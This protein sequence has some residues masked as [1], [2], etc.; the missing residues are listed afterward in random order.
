[1][2]PTVR[3]ELQELE[4]LVEEGLGN[5]E[6]VDATALEEH[7]QQEVERIKQ[8]LVHEVFSFEDER[9]LQ[10]YIQ[11]H[12]QGI[13]SLLDATGFVVSRERVAKKLEHL[14]TFIERHFAK[15]FDQ[16]AKAPEGYVR[17]VRRAFRQYAKRLF[18]ELSDRQ[19]EPRL[20]ELLLHAMWKLTDRRASG[21]TYRKV[22]YAKE[23]HLELTRLLSR[24]RGDP[25]GDINEELR[26]LLYYLNYN[27]TRALTY[28][29]HYIGGV[30]RDAETQEDKIDRLSLLLKKINQVQVRPG[31][32]YHPRCQSLKSQVNNY[33]TEEI[34]YLERLHQLGGGSGELRV[35][36]YRSGF[37]VQ[38]G[39]SVSQLSYL[40][41]VL[42]GCSVIE[43][44]NVAELL[45]FIARS[46]VT[47]QSAEVSFDSIRSKFYTVEDGTRA[48]VREVLLAMV[49]HIERDVR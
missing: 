35:D 27:S 10:R 38:V 14:L 11:Y 36:S 29:A 34:K 7:L 17:G 37:R 40:I 19:A 20:S 21:V 43:N 41:K 25:A 4:H 6:G 32:A 24:S 28:H 33:V 49:K 46:V 13:I 9:H 26:T 5:G 15:Y 47:K 16:D 48:A 42:L 18:R 30:L 22:M 1:M 39:M 23:V 44:T 45:R 8:A 3:Y 12:Q 31:L 2:A